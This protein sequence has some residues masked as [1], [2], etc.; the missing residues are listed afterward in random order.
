VFR[1]TPLEGA[2]GTPQYTFAVTVRH[3]GNA[4]ELCW[5]EARDV[6]PDEQ[7]IEDFFYWTKGLRFYEP[8]G[9]ARD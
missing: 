3:Y 5:R 1:M 2:T 7:K 8:T 4:I 9:K 6:A